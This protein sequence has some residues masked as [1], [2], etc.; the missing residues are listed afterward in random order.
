MFDANIDIIL[1]SIRLNNHTQI[2]TSTSFLELNMVFHI[3]NY[4]KLELIFYYEFYKMLFIKHVNINFFIN[5]FFIN[6][7]IILKN[8]EDFIEFYNE[9]SS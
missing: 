9:C 1:E 2:F 8:E 5:N 6:N 7:N 4:F 3:Y